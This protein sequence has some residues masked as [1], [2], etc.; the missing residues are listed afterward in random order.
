MANLVTN[1]RPPPRTLPGFPTASS[2]RPKTLV[3]KG[4]S[5]RKRWKDQD[6]AI[7][8]WESRH[9]TIENYD[10][11]GIHS[12][13]RRAL[14]YLP[15][16][17]IYLP[18]LLDFS[19]CSRSCSAR[20]GFLCDFSLFRRVNRE[21]CLVSGSAPGPA[22]AGAAQRAAVLPQSLKRQ[23]RPYA[24]TPKIKGG[25]PFVGPAALMPPLEDEASREN[26]R[27]SGRPG[28]RLDLASRRQRP[29]RYWVGSTGVEPLR[30]SKCS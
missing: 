30:S 10:S 11:R 3:G 9:G 26:P 1:R 15:V 23:F 12:A 22:A 17:P 29:A 18:V 19:P 7:Y 5:L 8:E 2:V 4:S 27:G 6:G 13:S 24:N 28:L 21:F 14:P 16:M 20:P 25:G